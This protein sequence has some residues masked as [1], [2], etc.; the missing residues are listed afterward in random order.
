[1]TYYEQMLIILSFIFIFFIVVLFDRLHK[2]EEFLKEVNRINDLLN[3]NKLFIMHELS[4]IKEGVLNFMNNITLDLN[5]EENHE[6]KKSK[7]GPIN[8]D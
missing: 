6:E 2:Y 3:N 5:N 7:E 4:F 8:N 1:M